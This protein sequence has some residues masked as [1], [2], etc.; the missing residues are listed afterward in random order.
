MSNWTGF[1]E[2]VFSDALS[3]F[4]N[5]LGGLGNFFSLILLIVALAVYIQSNKNSSLVIGVILLFNA[6]F[7]ILFASIIT[8]ILFIVVGI[9]AGMEMYRKYYKDL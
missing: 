5:A 7:A 6:L 3:P 8:F 1:N 4:S 9:I 2:T